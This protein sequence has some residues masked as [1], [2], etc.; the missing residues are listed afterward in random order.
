MLKL[1]GNIRIVTRIFRVDDLH[2]VWISG[3]D[4]MNNSAMSAA[5]LRDPSE[6]KL[7]NRI[8]P[9][10]Q[11]YRCHLLLYNKNLSLAKE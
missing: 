10:H 1:E 4:R 8:S 7:N 5:Q 2:P 3:V 11:N 6:Q 9:I